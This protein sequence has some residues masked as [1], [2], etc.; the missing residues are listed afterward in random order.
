MSGETGLATS[1]RPL[2][3]TSSEHGAGDYS[4]SG[5]YGASGGD[6]VAPMSSRFPVLRMQRSRVLTMREAEERESVEHHIGALEDTNRELQ[7]RC[8]MLKARLAA[9]D[10]EMASLAKEQAKGRE[11]EA[12]RRRGAGDLRCA[13]TACCGEGD[14]SGVDAKVAARCEAILKA[15]AAE[16]EASLEASAAEVE[17]LHCKLHVA[18]QSAAV[19]RQENQSS[20]KQL[21]CLEEELRACQHDRDMA[22]HAWLRLNEEL[23]E[24]REVLS[25]QHP[26]EFASMVSARGPASMRTRMSVVMMNEEL[27]NMMNRPLDR[28]SSSDSSSSEDVEVLRPEVAAARPPPLP[29]LADGVST[30]TVQSA[31]VAKAPPVIDT[32]VD[33]EGGASTR[34]GGADD[35]SGATAAES[36]AEAGC[37]LAPRLG[38]DEPGSPAKSEIRPPVPRLSLAPLSDGPRRLG[39]LARLGTELALTRSTSPAALR[40]RSTSD[41]PREAPLDEAPAAGCGSGWLWGWLARQPAPAAPVAETLSASTAA[42]LV[43]AWPAPA[44]VEGGDVSEGVARDGS[45]VDRA[46]TASSV[47]SQASLGIVDL[48]D[49]LAKLEDEVAS[50]KKLQ[51]K[52]THSDSGRGRGSGAAAAPFLFVLGDSS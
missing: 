46:P 34:S 30:A 26:E 50:L 19:A 47:V 43:P 9:A 15:S 24:M 41:A 52:E 12:G 35:A 7:G 16:W 10:E 48:F 32:D 36:E 38:A 27:D 39:P 31:P 22:V 40:S 11:D 17:S 25:T 20:I 13:K 29:V 3:T 18:D 21:R 14:E 23:Q 8:E 49:T 45:P 5:G 37:A 33:S 44:W 4:A 1:P 51:Q 2:S 28:D 6:G 42:P